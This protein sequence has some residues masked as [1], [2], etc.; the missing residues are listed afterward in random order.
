MNAP[1]VSSRR[2]LLAG[3]AAA[4]SLAAL[5]GCGFELRKP[6]VFAFRSIAVRGNSAMVNLI[7]RNLKAAGTVTVVE[8]GKADEPISALVADAVLEVLAEDRSRLVVSTNSVGLVRD[9]ELLFRFR[10]KLTAP[11]GKELLGATTIEQRRDLTYNETNA[12]AKESEAELLYRDMQNDVAQQ[13]LRRLG[14]VKQL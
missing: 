1:S 2:G 13:V 10:F 11:G 9:V 8:G 14:A 5:S 3:A 7:R 4:V 12:L 6:P